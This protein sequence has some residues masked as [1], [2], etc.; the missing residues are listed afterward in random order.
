MVSR[1]TRI[2]PSRSYTG[3]AITSLAR[4]VPP[5]GMRLTRILEM[6]RTHARSVGRQIGPD[7][8]RDFVAEIIRQDFQI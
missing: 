5:T 7:A 3:T 8:L 1:L 4:S 6:F 2:P